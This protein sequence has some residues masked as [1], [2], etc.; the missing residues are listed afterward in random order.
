M[1]QPPKDEDE[2]V[3]RNIELQPKDQQRI[4]RLREKLEASSDSEIL[5]RALKVLDE[6]IAEEEQGRRILVRE[7]NGDLVSI[8]LW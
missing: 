1:A 5:R 4:E 8:R 3:R 2:L 7:P 6:L